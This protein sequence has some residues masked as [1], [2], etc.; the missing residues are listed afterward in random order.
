MYV[1]VLPAMI[2]LVLVPLEVELVNQGNRAVL[3]GFRKQLCLNWGCSVVFPLTGKC[4][5]VVVVLPVA[6]GEKAEAKRRKV[7]RPPYPLPSLP[8]PALLRS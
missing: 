7:P 6:M 4:V 1:L 3:A 5:L 2:S 8:H